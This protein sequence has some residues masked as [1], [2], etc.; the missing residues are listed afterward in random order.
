MLQA[1]NRRGQRAE[2]I[3]WREDIRKNKVAYLLFL[4]ALVYFIIFNYIPMGG[5]AMAFQ[6][7]SFSKG[8]FGSE[9]VGWMNFEELFMDDTFLLVLRN[10][11]CM[12]LLN[13]TV[14]FV[15]P[16]IFALL[17]CQIS[18]PGVRRPLQIISYMPHFVAAVVV[19]QLVAEFLGRNGALTDL[20]TALGLER[21]NWLGNGDVPVFWL[22]NCFTEVWQEL[23]FSSIIYVAAIQSVNS[24]YHEAAAIDGA[25]RWQRVFKIVIPSILPIM[26]MMFVLKCGTFFTQGFDKV[27]LLYQPSTYDTA[28]CLTTFT[29]RMSFTGRP[30]YGLSTAS[31]LFQSVVCFALLIISNT[32]SKK[33]TNSSLF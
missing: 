9:F 18:R 20:L 17:L 30:N 1:V 28:D 4:P 26:V 10:T 16:I 24:D 14:G 15:C 27:L 32:M 12:A 21:Q 22:I 23:G 29:Y 31:G 33:L 2:K 13:L 8:L 6:D 11:V 19:C 3:T 7:Y 25:N 5:I